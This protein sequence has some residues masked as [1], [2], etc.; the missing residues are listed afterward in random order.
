MDEGAG[1]IGSD[2]EVVSVDHRQFTPTRSTSKG[3]L[4]RGGGGGEGAGRAEHL[5]GL[6]SSPSVFS[7]KNK[8]VST[9][10]FDTELTQV[11]CDFPPQ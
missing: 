11:Q 10:V 1:D 8:T 3:L 5:L 2:R 7:V 4:E 9:L 6:L